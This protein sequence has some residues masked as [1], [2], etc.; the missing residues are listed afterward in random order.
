MPRVYYTNRKNMAQSYRQR[1]TRAPALL[2]AANG[3]NVSLV[4][5]ARK[6][7]LR[8]K[9]YERAPTDRPLTENLYRSEQ[10]RFRGLVGEVRNTA[11]YAQIRDEAQGISKLWGHDKELNFSGGAAEETR[12]QRLENIRN[13]QR[14][15]MSGG[16]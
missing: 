5:Q 10:V 13:A 15:I 4:A 11:P 9:V 1:I 7:I 16:A 2:R 14:I 3:A 6:A 8:K 12:E